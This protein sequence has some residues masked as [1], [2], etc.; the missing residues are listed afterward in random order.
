M[1]TAGYPATI[2]E[3]EY[4]RGSVDQERPT[5]EDILLQDP[6]DVQIINLEEVKLE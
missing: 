5:S 2:P 1:R 3:E 6:L 4:L